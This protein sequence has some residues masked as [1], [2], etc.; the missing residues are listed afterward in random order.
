MPPTVGQ[1]QIPGQGPLQ[2]E[3]S[4]NKCGEASE[5]LLAQHLLS[6]YYVPGSAMPVI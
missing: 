4:K 2:S 6:T 5:I 1:A 3:V